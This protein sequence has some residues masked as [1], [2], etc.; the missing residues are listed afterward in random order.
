MLHS[1][2]DLIVWQKS[3][4]LVVLVYGLTGKFPNEEKFGLTSQMRIAAVSI[5]SNIAEG[6]RRGTSKEYRQFLQIAYGSG[7]ELE[8][9][10][11]IGLRLT[12]L[13]ENDYQKADNLLREVM[14]MLN[15]LMM[16]VS[17]ANN[18]IT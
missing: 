11:E 15:S 14:K 7:G 12:F 4:D 2:R 13:K 16:K 5:P 9:Q 6:R 8:T 10:L 17:S 18:L 3:M 1:F